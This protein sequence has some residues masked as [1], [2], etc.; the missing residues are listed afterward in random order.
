MSTIPDFAPD[1]RQMQSR[2]NQIM[3][4][5]MIDTNQRGA[6][7]CMIYGKPGSGKTKLGMEILQRVV[8]EGKRIIMFDTSG[9]YVSLNNH[10]GLLGRATPIRFSTFEDINIISAAIKQGLDPW[11]KV[12]GILLDEVSSMVSSDLIRVHE[13]ALAGHYGEKTQAEAVKE[14]KPAWPEYNR[15][16]SRF[17]DLYLNMF[18]NAGISVV[19][20]AH[21]RTLKN[22]QGGIA[23]F[24]PD[25]PPSLETPA[26]AKM[27]LVCRMDTTV[28]NTRPGQ[29]PAY[30]RILQ[31]HPSLMVTAKTRIPFSKASVDAEELPGM[32]L[33]WL[34]AGAQPADVP[35]EVQA[36]VYDSVEILPEA[37][38]A[39]AE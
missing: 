31:V 21:Q 36:E 19:A 30:K 39:V 38:Q 11:D 10:P 15:E 9:N 14:G 6:I 18:A 20:T 5:G 3:S 23:G 17:T 12:G 2:L 26:H 4:A 7:H 1:T 33:A 13:A 22:A 27:D 34:E 8:P 29:A 35:T 25:F 28:T 16:V 24:G 32:L 37:F